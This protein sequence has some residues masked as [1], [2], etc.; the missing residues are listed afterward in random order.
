MCIAM[1]YAEQTV[2]AI[3]MVMQPEHWEARRHRAWAHHRPATGT[4]DNAQRLAAIDAHN[5]R[6]SLL[7]N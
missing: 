6:I 3:T 5:S 1:S 7:S 4:M 2:D